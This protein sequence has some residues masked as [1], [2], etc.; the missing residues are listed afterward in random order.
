MLAACDFTPLELTG[1][2]GGGADAEVLG[3]SRTIRG[4]VIDFQTGGPLANPT[5]TTS[6]L[7]PATRV[8][9]NGAEFTLEGV[10]NNSTFQLLASVGETHRATFGPAVQVVEEDITGVEVPVVS[11][12]FLAAA[13]SEFQ[14]SPQASRGIL[15]AQIVDQ[16]D[17]AQANIPDAAFQVVSPVDGPHFFNQNLLPDRNARMS[18]TSG[19]SMFAD[20]PPGTFELAPAPDVTLAMPRVP[21]AA[22]T[23]TLARVRVT[24]DP[25]PPLPTNVSFSAQITPIFAGRG[26]VAC[27]SGGQIGHNLGGLKL[28]GPSSQVYRELVVD[29]SG[30]VVTSAPE[31]S[32]VLTRPS[33]EVP[34]DV[35]P[36]V[37][38][39]S[40]K[41]PDYILL[42]VWIREGAQEN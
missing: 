20:V 40:S 19:W 39:A 29:S 6:G 32:L 21:I 30:R 8:S 9:V 18:S 11:E 15:I 10:P 22:N 33:L 16:T 5:I 37:T 38:F 12:A 4:R 7:S 13:A 41:D 42:L 34:A 25:P 28:D 26:C 31:T 27:H 24:M 35:H 2:G 14:I 23:V 1:D 36:N 3:G 17:R